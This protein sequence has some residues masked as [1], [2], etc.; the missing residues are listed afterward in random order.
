MRHRLQHA[1]GESFSRH[2]WVEARGRLSYLFPTTRAKDDTP[3]KERWT[4]REFAQALSHFREIGQ[5]GGW[6]SERTTS[7]SSMSSVRK[8]PERRVGALTS[9][10]M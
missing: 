9:G 7:Q 8:E 3:P 4:F 6:Q 10:R 2:L 5:V 1:Q